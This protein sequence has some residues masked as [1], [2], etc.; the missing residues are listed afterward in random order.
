MSE[1]NAPRDDLQEQVLAFLRADDPP[2]LGRATPED[3]LIFE[4][5][6]VAVRA[7]Q[8][9]GYTPDLLVTVLFALF[10][11]GPNEP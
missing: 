7:A 11:E 10:S 1:D 6:Q 5:L 2:G 4:H 8:V 3:F 9:K